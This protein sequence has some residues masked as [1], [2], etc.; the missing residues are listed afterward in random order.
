[1]AYYFVFQNKTYIQER[2]GGYLW[3]PQRNSHDRLLHHWTRVNS[4]QKNDIIIHS[5]KTFIRAVS[6][7][8]DDAYSASIP[9]EIAEHQWESAG[10]RVDVHYYEIPQ[11]IHSQI[12]VPTLR[13]L[14]PD[15]DGP[16]NAS[17]RGNM[18]YLFRFNRLALHYLLDETLKN[19][20][21][22]QDVMRV[23]HLIEVID[24]LETRQYGGETDFSRQVGEIIVRNREVSIFELKRALVLREDQSDIYSI[25]GIVYRRDPRI[26]AIALLRAKGQCD[27]CERDAPFISVRGIPYLESHHI[28]PRAE[29]GP[30]SLGNVGAL[31][32]NC[33]RGMHL[34]SDR[35]DRQ[36]KLKDIMEQKRLANIDYRG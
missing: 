18:G 3:A 2:D 27:R 35:V 7:A 29:G 28:I 33:H 12:Y 8:S 15:S 21:T 22:S 13:N 10:W 14:Y 5:Y 26:A 24:E 4:V 32:P 23:K 36:K 17:N 34:A 31:C 16:Y 25:N 19:Q 6:I 30:D 20:R 9:P 1:M 11:P